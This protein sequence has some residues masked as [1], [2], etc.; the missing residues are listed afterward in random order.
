[1]CSFSLAAGDCHHDR[2]EAM[3]PKADVRIP[4][5]H[6]SEKS[7]A[8]NNFD[9]VE[10]T[11]LGIDDMTMRRVRSSL[12]DYQMQFKTW[13]ALGQH[14]IAKRSGILVVLRCC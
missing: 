3:V 11:L 4:L 1:M 9:C 14:R 2:P 7:A 10:H 5:W 12:A 13:D 6:N 8:T